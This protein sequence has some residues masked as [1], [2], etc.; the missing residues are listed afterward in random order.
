MITDRF[1][2]IY[3]KINREKCYAAKEKTFLGRNILVS[4]IQEP[5]LEPLYNR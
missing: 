2:G 4:K 3:R 5:F 1:C